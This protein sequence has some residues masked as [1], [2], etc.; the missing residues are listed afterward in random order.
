MLLTI[1][2]LLVSIA[3]ITTA[4]ELK[5]DRLMNMKLDHWGKMRAEGMF[6]SN[7]VA[8]VAQK[9]T[10]SGG[11]AGNYSCDHVDLLSFLS[12]EDMGSTTR[13]GNDVWGIFETS[14][15]VSKY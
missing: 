14:Y 9:V 6:D 12:H 2:L 13:E 8:S 3:T 11:K 4:D 1:L 5:M 10:C 15:T 7:R